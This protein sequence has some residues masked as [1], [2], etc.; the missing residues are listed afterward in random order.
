MFK[1]NNCSTYGVVAFFLLLQ[2]TICATSDWEYK[3][4]SPGASIISYEGTETDNIEIPNYCYRMNDRIS[5]DSFGD[6]IHSI[7]NS[8][9]VSAFFSNA[10]YYYDD[11]RRTRGITTIRSYAFSGCSSLSSIRLSK[12]IEKI[13]KYAFQDC[14][15]LEKIII[16][17]SVT[18]IGD[19]AFD[20]CTNLRE[21]IFCGDYTY[22]GAPLSIGNE[23][24]SRCSDVKVYFLHETLFKNN[25]TLG[26]TNTLVYMNVSPNTTWGGCPVFSV[27]EEIEAI[28]NRLAELQ[29]TIDPSSPVISSLNTAVK[30]LQDGE[31]EL[32]E[33]ITVLQ[34]KD[35]ELTD[36]IASVN[37]SI[38]ALQVKDTELT[39]D[40]ASTN[41]AIFTIQA[42]YSELT[43][44]I[45]TANTAIDALQTRNTELTSDIAAVNTVIT[46]LQNERTELVAANTAMQSDIDA[47]KATVSGLM[48]LPENQGEAG[49]VLTKTVD[50][51]EWKNPYIVVDEELDANSMNSVQ[52]KVVT[53]A[54]DTLAI[55]DVA[56]QSGIDALQVKE[57][58][59]DNE[60]TSANTAIASL[61]TKDM[62]FSSSIAELQTK[63]M[64]LAGNIAVAN[65]AITALQLKDTELTGNINYNNSAISS[66]NS[67]IKVLQTSNT[68]ILSSIMGLHATD[69]EFADSISSTNTAITVL[70]GKSVEL[71]GGLSAVN[72]AITALQAE[73]VSISSNAS[74]I[75]TLKEKSVTTNEAIDTIQTT[76]VSLSNR[77]EDIYNENAML[78][79]SNEELR[80]QVTI[81]NGILA[82]GKAGQVLACSADGEPAWET[83][84]PAVSKNQK[85]ELA[86]GWNLVA[87][88]GDI[89]IPESEKAL[90]DSL[91]M[92][93]YDRKSQIYMK[94]GKIE[95]FGAYWIF[96]KEDCTLHFS[97]VGVVE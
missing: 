9:V 47:I 33:S 22:S 85:I 90:L 88:A 16:P 63:E 14:T 13:E 6:G 10:P 49:Q 61:Q 48:E 86:C 55:S 78:K 12:Y 82:G 74:A 8:D 81:L 65:T 76:L 84:V 1:K 46:G 70:E 43:S 30:S 71:A 73:S 11:G 26:G 87:L 3:N 53:K 31:V 38:A 77:L 72:D 79:S 51:F 89:V 7:F 28:K 95:Q 45:G 19:G 41:N 24:F 15:S 50:G 92:F 17:S 94:P 2:C 68:E 60:I 58:E 64:E 23:I 25:P 91:I 59:L 40:I 80:R 29:T 69:A 27:L 37:T 62:E 42:K 32:N 57:V 52:N 34:A 20:G 66:A 54:I 5:I 93:T 39:N 18:T 21:V 56:L 67:A 97:V 36:S 35:T 96:T 44:N 4:D 75:A 83:R